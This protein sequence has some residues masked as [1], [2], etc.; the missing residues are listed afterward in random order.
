MVDKINV[1]LNIYFGEDLFLYRNKLWMRD[2]V[3]LAVIL[4]IPE[5]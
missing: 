1:D 3:N 5:D 2:A 4:Y